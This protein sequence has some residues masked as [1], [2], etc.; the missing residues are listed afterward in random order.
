M[1][2]MAAFYPKDDVS[3]AVLAVTTLFLA[4]FI[5][6]PHF[7]HSYQLFYKGFMR[8]AFSSASILRHRY[9]FAGIM[10]PAVLATFFASAVAQGIAPLL[11]L[12]ANVMFFTVGWHYAK[13]G[14]GI[15]MLDAVQKGIRFDAREKRHLLWSTHLAWPTMWLMANDELAAH[16]FWGLT[17]YT[18]DT[19][20]VLLNTMFT[21]TGISA[22]VVA[23][24][25]LLRW[26]ATRALPI[27]GL[28][29][30]AT[31]IYV[32]LMIVRF[33]P[34]LL[35]LNPVFHSLQYL[36]VVWRYQLNAEAEN[37]RERPVGGSDEA[38]PAWLRTATAGIV[39]FVLIGGLLGG[40]GFWVVP[41]FVD[42]I[43]GYDRAIF[44]TTM[45]LF[46]GWTFIN[47]HHYFIDSVIWR[48]ENTETRRYLFA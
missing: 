18:F 45:F 11:G 29:A 2:L 8:K 25:L 5:N 31:S 36:C 22:A 27:N 30:Y 39:R 14:Y 16:D 47:I 42:S 33:D 38:G 48:H 17:Y 28:V 10:V 20:D 34:V 1:A 35:L 43:A 32:W 41:V 23:R 3:R 26:R 44:G 6:H 9:R 46:I 7:A 21:L 37:V 40:A 19:P 4:N 13:Q 15:L 24:D 12:A